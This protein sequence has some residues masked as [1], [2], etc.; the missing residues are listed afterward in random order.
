MARA[1]RVVGNFHTVGEVVVFVSAPNWQGGLRKGAL[2][3]KKSKKLKGKR[4]TVGA[5]TLQEIDSLPVR[6]TSVQ[7]PLVETAQQSPSDVLPS[8]Q[9]EHKEES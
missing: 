7:L 9:P 8:P 5:F 2:E 4:V 3:L 1:W 6:G